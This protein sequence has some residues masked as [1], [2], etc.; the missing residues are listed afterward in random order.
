[1]YEILEQAD[2]GDPLLAEFVDF[3]KVKNLNPG[4]PI[5]A[6]TMRAFLAVS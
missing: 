6:P 2:S 3:M 1:V 4:T 5:E